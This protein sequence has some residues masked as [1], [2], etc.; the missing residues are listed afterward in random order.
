MK[1]MDFYI[2]PCVIESADLAKEITERLLK[3]LEPFKNEINLHFFAGRGGRPD[4]GFSFLS[5]WVMVVLI[6]RNIHP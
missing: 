2:G 5:Q 4:L 6:S 3:D 1:K